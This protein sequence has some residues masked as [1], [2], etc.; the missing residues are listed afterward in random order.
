MHGPYKFHPIIGHLL[1]P[2]SL[3]MF[4]IAILL[5][6]DHKTEARL[7][8]KN[9]VNTTDA[10]VVW[11]LKKGTIS[12]SILENHYDYS[13]TSWLSLPYLTSPHQ[14]AIFQQGTGSFGACRLESL[15]FFPSSSLLHC[16]DSESDES[17]VGS[18]FLR[19]THDKFMHGRNM[20]P[21][22][23]SKILFLGAAQW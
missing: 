11:S 4:L 17:L 1:I 7:S 14:T 20:R 15:F 8:W 18:I 13:T 22:A 16:P 9:P 21:L 19:V 10:I 6:E 12:S 3:Q 5:Q 2:A 23:T